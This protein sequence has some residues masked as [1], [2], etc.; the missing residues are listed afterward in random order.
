MKNNILI[1]VFSLLVNNMIYSQNEYID[2]NDGHTLNLNG[3]NRLPP[4]SV[5][6]IFAVDQIGNITGWHGS[7]PWGCTSVDEDGIYLNRNRHGDR[8]SVV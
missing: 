6:N 4:A 1:L 2:F 8:K 5:P 3:F 7:Y